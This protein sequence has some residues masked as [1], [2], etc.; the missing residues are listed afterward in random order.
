[1]KEK[2][3]ETNLEKYGVEYVAQFPEFKDK[4]KQTNLEKYGVEFY[5]QTKECQ[6]KRKKTSLEKYGVE[7]VSQNEEIMEKMTTNMYKSKEYTFPSGNIIKIQGY[8]HFALNDLLLNENICENDIITG[9][10]NVPSIWYNDENGKKRR[11]Y[12][13]IY[14]PSKNLCIEV[15]SKWTITLHNNRILLKQTAGKV[16]GYKYEIWVYDHKGLKIEIYK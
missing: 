3:K 15:K 11:H 6:E 8:E 2:T 4:I 9:S 10:S 14:I 7:H 5:S 13:D 16:I 1:M 12:V